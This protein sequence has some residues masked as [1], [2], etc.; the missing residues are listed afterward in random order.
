VSCRYVAPRGGI[1][2]VK[3]FGLRLIETFAQM[4]QR[5]FFGAI[6]TVWTLCGDGRPF[7]TGRNGHRDT[8]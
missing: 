2:T 1:V 8:L 7:S 6:S 4:G 5:L 3:V